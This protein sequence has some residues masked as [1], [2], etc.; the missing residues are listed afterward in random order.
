MPARAARFQYS[1]ATLLWV[2]FGLA[3]VLSFVRVLGYQSILF[4]TPVVIGIVGYLF[5]SLIR[6]PALTAMAGEVAL[7]LYVLSVPLVEECGS[8]AGWPGGSLRHYELYCVPLYAWAGLIPAPWFWDL[9]QV[10]STLCEM[11]PVLA[12]SL[13]AYCSALA[14]G[15]GFLRD[16]GRRKLSMPITL[17]GR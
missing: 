6:R 14:L 1:I 5:G 7:V 13:L 12:G 9:Y 16:R 10:W 8:A 3:L 2:T 11:R 17:D 4:L 15:L